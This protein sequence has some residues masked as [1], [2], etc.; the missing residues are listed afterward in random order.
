M[1][2]AGIMNE[3]SRKMPHRLLLW[4]WLSVIVIS[5]ILIAVSLPRM[6]QAFIESGMGELI[7]SYRDS[8]GSTDSMSRTISLVFPVPTADPE[9][10]RYQVFETPFQGT[11]SRH[12]RIEALLRGPDGAALREGAITFIP[13]DTRLI[14]L[15]VSNRIAFVDLTKEFLG[16]MS[17]DPELDRRRTQLKRTI[18]SDGSLRDVVIL[19]D[20]KEW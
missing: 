10:Y 9:T 11:L 17:L 7:S 16:K 5:V 6:K 3:S 13:S 1:V 20:G 12:A 15:S 2:Y 19:V 8:Q 18:L 4:L 14:G